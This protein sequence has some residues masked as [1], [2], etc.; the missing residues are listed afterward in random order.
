MG[1]NKRTA[2]WL[3]GATVLVACG[4]VLLGCDSTPNDDGDNGAQ[5]NLVVVLEKNLDSGEDIIYVRFRRDGAGIAGGVVAIDGDTIE[6]SSAS[7][8]GEKTYTTPRWLHG[9]KIQITAIDPVESF[10]YRDSVVIPYDFVIEHVIPANHIWRPINGN[11]NVT[12]TTSVGA[13][14]YVVSVKART[15]NSTAVPFS[16]YSESQAGLSHVIPP[17]AFQ[18]QFNNVIEDVYDL[19]VIAY[20]PNFIARP[21]P[22]Y[23]TPSTDDVRLPIQKTDIDGG[24]A[25]LVV[26]DRDTL[27]VQLE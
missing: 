17:D 1:Q 24:I 8:R 25:A 15:S 13:A 4:L 14:N 20:S 26:A 21:N 6:T 19:K 7:G 16:E 5:Y 3:A 22:P 2:G 18:D 11:A 9:E 10:V 23:K 12:W 27:S